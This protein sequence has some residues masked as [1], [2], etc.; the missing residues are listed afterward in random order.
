LRDI[1]GNLLA[2]NDNWKD[3]QETQ[4]QTTGWAPPNDSESAISAT[5]LPNNYTAILRGSQSTTGD[6]LV[7]VY[8]LD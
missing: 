4:I 1:N 8:A 5:L 6:A 7:E 3:T 2:S